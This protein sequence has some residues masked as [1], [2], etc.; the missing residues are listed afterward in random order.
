MQLVKDVKPLRSKNLFCYIFDHTSLLLPP[1]YTK[2]SLLRSKISNLGNP[3]I[4]LFSIIFDVHRHVDLRCC[5]LWL[6]AKVVNQ[7]QELA[8]QICR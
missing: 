5:W 8:K 2:R 6:M 3:V 1:K 4:P 7:E